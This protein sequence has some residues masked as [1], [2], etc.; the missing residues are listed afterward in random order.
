[1]AGRYLRVKETRPR[2][3]IF[4]NRVAVVPHAA[5]MGTRAGLAAT[6]SAVAAPIRPRHGGNASGR[7]HAVVGH[8]PR[9]ATNPAVSGLR[10]YPPTS[11]TRPVANG[12]SP[13]WWGQAP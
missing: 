11:E 5:R 7:G 13:P 9:R 2:C 1:M 10:R 6:A 12:G 4:F 3:A 8:R